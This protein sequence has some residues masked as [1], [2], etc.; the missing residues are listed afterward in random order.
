[1]ST[2]GENG[3]VPND[4]IQQIIDSAH[5]ITFEEREY[6]S[7]RTQYVIDRSDCPMGFDLSKSLTYSER[8]T[9]LREKVAL[10]CPDFEVSGFDH[11]FELIRV[12]PKSRCVIF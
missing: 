6:H 9:L 11:G 3:N 7:S 4:V 2:M 12:R 8:E 5:K 1:M 10:C